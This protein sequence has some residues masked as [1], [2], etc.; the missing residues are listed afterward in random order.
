MSDKKRILVLTRRDD[1][2]DFDTAPSMAKMLNQQNGEVQYEPC[3]LE[4]ISMVFD[5]TEL[6][7]LNSNTGE[8]VAAYDGIFLLGW[9]KKRKHEEVALA[10][11]LY[12]QEHDVKAYNTEALHNRSRSKISQYVLSALRGIVTTPFVIICDSDRLQATIAASSLEYPLIVKSV[13]GSRGTH[14]FLVN[15]DEELRESLAQAPTKA[16]VA[17]T[18]IPNE[19]DYRLLVTGGEVTLA[20]HRRSVTDSHLNN[21]SQGGKATIIPLEELSQDMCADAVTI[22]GLLRREITGV[23]MIIDKGTG[24]HY[25][26]EANNMPQ[27]STG[28]FV[29]EKA[30]ALDTFFTKW[31][32]E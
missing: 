1:R 30:A 22:A 13:T 28:S 5:G 23:D 25:F 3:F 21:T 10:V 20:I 8:D 26:L 15:N 12:A 18:F 2:P 27:L 7:M 31:T 24:K 14:N 32:K 16:F 29:P 17:Q 4:E 9:F 6:K 11:S 19:G